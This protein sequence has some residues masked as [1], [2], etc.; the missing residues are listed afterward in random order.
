MGVPCFV[1]SETAPRRVC[2][3]RSGDAR[4]RHCISHVTY[5]GDGTDPFQRRL[6]VAFRRSACIQSGQRCA[7][8]FGGHSDDDPGPSACGG[9]SLG[10]IPARI[11][12]F[13][14]PSS[15]HPHSDPKTP[16]PLTLALKKKLL[17]RRANFQRIQCSVIARAHPQGPR[18][19]IPGPTCHR[20]S[21]SIPPIGPS[22]GLCSP[23]PVPSGDDEDEDEDEDVAIEVGRCWEM[24]GP[25]GK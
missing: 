20:L 2:G 6:R 21:L 13:F 23:A 10:S 24:H 3:G 7:V 4:R 8:Q 5:R 9:D 19:T 12:L 1:C 25:L 22:I 11:N 14:V 15:P 16:L 17:S 18:S